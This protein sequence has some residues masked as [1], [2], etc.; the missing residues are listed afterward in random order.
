MTKD[1]STLA[2]PGQRPDRPYYYSSDP[3]TALLEID[4]G[5]WSRPLEVKF[6]VITALVAATTD[7]Q[8]LDTQGLDTQG[9]D[10]Q[11]LDTQGLDTQGLD[12]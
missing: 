1:L 7:T 8:G 9:L 2:L 4:R 10:T 6:L 3:L 5:M 11:G 12:L